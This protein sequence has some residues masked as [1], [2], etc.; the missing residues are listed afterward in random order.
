MADV[1]KCGTGF[2]M[3]SYNHADAA[4]IAVSECRQVGRSC[5]ELARE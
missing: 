5:G 1:Q 4:A 3:P 2:A